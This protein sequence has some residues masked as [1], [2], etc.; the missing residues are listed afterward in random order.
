MKRQKRTKY[1]FNYQQ[2][3][4]EYKELCSKKNRTR[5]YTD[6]YKKI[7][8][9][10]KHYDNDKLCDFEKYLSWLANREDERRKGIVF[11]SNVLSYVISILLPIIAIVV[12]LMT[13]FDSLQSSLDMA[14]LEKAGEVSDSS[15]NLKIIAEQL[16]YRMDMFSHIFS[17]FLIAGYI[18]IF[19]IFFMLLFHILQRYFKKRDKFLRDYIECIVKIKED[20]LEKENKRYVFFL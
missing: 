7:E 5:T 3:Y 6:W 15:S 13:Y 18:V 9:K 19:Y 12:S 16:Q 1:G 2:E 17:L 20:K 11:L 4:N 14:I 10:Y 8:S